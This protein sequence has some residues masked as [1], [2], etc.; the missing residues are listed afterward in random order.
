MKITLTIIHTLI[1]IS[2]FGQIG[3][4]GLSFD[5]LYETKCFIEEDDDE[6]SQFYL[7]FYPDGKVI[8]VGTDCEGK[9]DEI[10]DWFHINAGQVSKGNYVVTG[11]KIK[12]S[13]TGLTGTVHYKGRITDN[14]IK[15]TWKSSVNGAKGRDNYTFVRLTGLK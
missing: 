9:L 15:I 8:S 13:T 14:E 6:G 1:W 10:T 11:T 2:F 7:R 4:S 12:F 3:Q 5:G